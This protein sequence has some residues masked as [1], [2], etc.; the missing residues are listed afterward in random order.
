MKL[1][2]LTGAEYEF[3]KET[4]LSCKAEFEELMKEKEWYS[5][6]VTDRIESSLEILLTGVREDAENLQG[7]LC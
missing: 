3:L 2:E 5:T 1:L 7:K 4:L 6:E